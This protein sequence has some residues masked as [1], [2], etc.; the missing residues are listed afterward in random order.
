ML[1]RRLSVA[2]LGLAAALAGANA[3]RAEVPESTDVIKLAVLEW[4]GQHITVF[5]A[6]EILTRMG[7]A[8]EYVTAGSYPSA[9]ATADG[10][11]TASL[12]LWD[13]NL[14]DFWPK[15]EAEGKVEKLTDLGLDGREGFLYPKFVEEMCPGMPAWD[16]FV[17][18]AELFATAETTPAGRF[19]EYPADWGT[20]ATTLFTEE[21]LNFEAIPA[22]SEGSLVAE[23]KS[24]VEK[25]QP[26]VMMFWA[27]HWVLAN[28][29]TGWVEIPDDLRIKYSIQK[30]HMWTYVWPEMKNKW[31]AAYNFLKAYRVDTGEQQIM[32]GLVDNDDQDA[33]EVAKKWVDE[34]EDVWKPWVDQAMM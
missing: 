2:A 18:C 23:L 25:K 33:Q 32:M 14:G 3:A 34:H 9:T 6:G 21:G 10:D 24:A 11:L 16:A 27:P 29:D 15:L 5:I 26:L 1:T 30:P 4:T 17:G 31:P 19:V 12:E 8:V 28:F 22:G 13:N 7:Y 20:R